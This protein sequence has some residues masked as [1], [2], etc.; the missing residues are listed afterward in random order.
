[1]RQLHASLAT[2]LDVMDLLDESAVNTP[3]ADI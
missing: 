1:L 3:L 2:L